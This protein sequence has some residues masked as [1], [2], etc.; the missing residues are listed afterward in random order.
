MLRID[1]MTP[2]GSKLSI[3]GFVVNDRGCQ[4]FFENGAGYLSGAFVLGY[5]N[6]TTLPQRRCIPPAGSGRSGRIEDPHVGG[7]I[8]PPLAEFFRPTEMQVLEEK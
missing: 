4:S 3:A 8:P 1:Q 2:M 6:A 5:T 7:S